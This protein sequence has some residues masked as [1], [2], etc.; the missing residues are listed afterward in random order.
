MWEEFLTQFNGSAFFKHRAWV[1]NDTLHLY[2]DAAQSLG[3][4]AIFR[5]E[6]FC[7]QWPENWKQYNITL[8][9]LYPI[10]AS[11]DS[12]GHYISNK[13]ITIFTDNQAL[14]FILNKLTSP[15]KRLCAS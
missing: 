9:E 15:D 1:N 12:W 14:T 5:V 13:R 10:V 7:G 6:W 2:T 3:H 4:G 8:L 11:V